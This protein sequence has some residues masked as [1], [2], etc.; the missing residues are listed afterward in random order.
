MTR[1]TK[2][3]TQRRGRIPTAIFV[4]GGVL[5]T[6]E[7]CAYLVGIVS[8]GILFVT[9]MVLALIGALCSVFADK[10]KAKTEDVVTVF[11]GFCFF[12]WIGWR[13]FIS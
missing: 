7:A 13:S 10:E 6:L 8:T 2:A 12:A 4:A 11:I 1:E 5:L 9:G 3:R